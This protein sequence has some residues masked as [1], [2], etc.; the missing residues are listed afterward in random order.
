MIIN[1]QQVSN[2]TELEA[3]I[4]DMSEESKVAIRSSYYGTTPPAPSTKDLDYLKYLKRAAVKDQ[5]IAEM[6]SENME[7]V[8]TGVWTVAD[9][10]GLTQDT[11]L[12]LV[13]DDISTLSFELAQAKINAATNP[14]LTND[15]KTAWIIKLQ[16]NLFNS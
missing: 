1:G 2:E 13:L 15:I 10:V 16:N 11:Q 12:K 14:L 5:I 8:R 9:L 7:R 3:L 6:A 4:A